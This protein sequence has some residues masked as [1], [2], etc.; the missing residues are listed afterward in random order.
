M[1]DAQTQT[2][3]D[4]TRAS[5]Q[6]A[7]ARAQGAIPAGLTQSQLRSGAA[8]GISGLPAR[9]QQEQYKEEVASQLQEV[10]QQAAEFEEEVAA[11][12]PALALPEYKQKEYQRVVEQIQNVAGGLSAKVAS[13]EQRVKYF[14]DLVSSTGRD[15]EKES[16]EAYSQRMADLNYNIAQAEADLQ[17]AREE[18]NV[19]QGGLQGTP[20]EVIEKFNTGELA[21]LADYAAQVEAGRFTTRQAQITNQ[22]KQ[23]AAFKSTSEYYIRNY[24]PVEGPKIVAQLEKWKAASVDWTDP[25]TAKNILDY[26]NINLANIK[27]AGEKGFAPTYGGAG[28]LFLTGFKGNL[29]ETGALGAPLKEVNISPNELITYMAASDLM[30]GGIVAFPKSGGYIPFRDRAVPTVASPTSVKDY[31]VITAG[32]Q[33]AQYEGKAKGTN[34]IWDFNKPISQRIGEYGIRPT[35][36]TPLNI[37]GPG[38]QTATNLYFGLEAAF[39]AGKEPLIPIPSERDVYYSLGMSGEIEKGISTI[40]T[41]YPNTDKIRKQTK[42]FVVNYLGPAAKSAIMNEPLIKTVSGLP[43]IT[44]AFATSAIRKTAPILVGG[45]NYLGGRIEAGKSAERMPSGFEVYKTSYL[46]RNK[47]YLERSAEEAKA[48]REFVVNYLGRPAKKVASV[49]IATNPLLIS[50]IGVTAGTGAV[51]SEAI[52]FF[53]YGAETFRT[54]GLPELKSDVKIITDVI[55]KAA[56][57]KVER[58]TNWDVFKETNLQA[59]ERRITDTQPTKVGAVIGKTVKATEQIAIPFSIQDVKALYERIGE[60]YKGKKTAG[61]IGGAILRTPGAVVDWAGTRLGLRGRAAFEAIGSL[62]PAEMERTRI[63][64]YPKSEENPLGFQYQVTKK[65]KSISYLGDVG[66]SLFK[67]GGTIGLYAG[68]GAAA[69]AALDVLIYSPYAAELVEGGPKGLWGYAKANPVETALSATYAG[70]R[71]YQV[72]KGLTRNIITEQSL[73]PNNISTRAELLKL[74]KEG[75]LLSLGKSLEVQQKYRKLLGLSPKYKASDYYKLIQTTKGQAKLAKFAKQLAREGYSPES[76]RNILG[77]KAYR[78]PRIYSFETG[79][80][81][82]GYPQTK[83]VPS[84]GTEIGGITSKGVLSFKGSV[85]TPI[86]KI[87]PIIKKI[88]AKESI[89]TARKNLPYGFKKLGTIKEIPYFAYEQPTQIITK[90]GDKVKIEVKGM[91]YY[92]YKSGKTVPYFRISVQT[93]SGK[94]ETTWVRFMRTTKKG[95]LKLGFSKAETSIEKSLNAYYNQRVLSPTE[96]VRS[97]A[98][99]RTLLTKYFKEVEARPGTLEFFSGTKT[100]EERIARIFESAKEFRA[101]GM[102]VGSKKTIEISIGKERLAFPTDT[103]YKFDE[104]YIRFMREIKK[105]ERTTGKT[106]PFTSVK[107]VKDNLPSS[108]MKRLEELNKLKSSGKITADQADWALNQLSAHFRASKQVKSINRLLKNYPSSGLPSSST[109]VVGTE[110]PT[111]VGGEEVVSRSLYKGTK[112]TA[113]QE[114]VRAPP[115]SQVMIVPQPQSVSISESMLKIE[116]PQV[117]VKGIQATKLTGELILGSRLLQQKQVQFIQP[118]VQMQRITPELTFQSPEVTLLTED[119]TQQLQQQQIQQQQLSQ[120]QIVMPVTIT[121]PSTPI[122]SVAIDIVP[123]LERIEIPFELKR[124]KRTKED[125]KKKKIRATGYEVQIRRRGKFKLAYPYAVP[126]EEALSIGAR[127]V[128]RTSAATFRIVPSKRP[129]VKT[130]MRLSSK[131]FAAAFRTPKTP[132]EL[133]FVQKK[134][135]RI[136]SPGEKK[137]ISLVGAAAVR[138]KKKGGFLI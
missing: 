5:Y 48:R 49:L 3:V 37:F 39:R 87:T 9:M 61:E 26:E 102:P 109:T 27:A 138:K 97:S 68:L 63:Y 31:G 25:N 15:I 20:E 22:A 80:G 73:Y 6:E 125:K 34:Y 122:T 105:A 33:F 65:V 13:A 62:Y 84:A 131:E 106:R 11:K 118:T 53:K 107:T 83:G 71:G 130:G 47:G 69:P 79:T 90:V 76:I 32:E 81:G 112:S 98:K 51:A 38:A 110:F 28:N 1:V 93:P 4:T 54:R 40:P 135:F 59:I 136:K 94:I 35:F 95:Q 16:P 129:A 43:Y 18:L 10:Q 17:T 114:F 46:E 113:I 111:Y 119:T 45:I 137:E 75:K 77:P 134:T 120:Q 99:A 96:A 127:K 104:S 23:D 58:R 52:P 41:S 100:N 19:Y 60:E 86:Y 89:L 72:Y 101:K 91:G 126:R 115:S 78:L 133:T 29:P 116:A 85:E 70:V 103:T 66:E 21:G 121:P 7:I 36:N 56:S 128:L 50:S 117:F 123:Q 42:E 132:A 24:G 67:V 57:T 14:R 2:Y 88:S 92:Q 124:K 74:Q 55:G 44:T 30:S 82:F 8:S 108:F 12:E 64:F